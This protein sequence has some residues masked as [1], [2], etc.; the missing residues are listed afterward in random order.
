[1]NSYIDLENVLFFKSV[2]IGF[3]KKIKRFK[4]WLFI[5]VLKIYL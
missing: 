5:F 2:K 3:E 4:N 1:M